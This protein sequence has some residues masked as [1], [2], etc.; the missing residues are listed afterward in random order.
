MEIGETWAYHS[1]TT[2]AVVPVAIVKVPTDQPARVLVRFTQAEAEGS[3]EWVP[4]GR[5]KVPWDGVDEWLE[6]DRRWTAI[7]ET[8]RRD[9][10]DPEWNAAEIVLEQCLDQSLAE[11]GVNQDAGLLLIKD[12]A[13]LAALLDIEATELSSDPLSFVVDGTL[14]VPSAVTVRVTRRAAELNAAALLDSVEREEARG[15]HEA[16]H[17]R[18]YPAHGRGRGWYVKPE[19]CAENAEQDRLIHQLIRRWCGVEGQAR[20]DE[21]KA[22]R[23]EARRLAQLAGR[24]IAALR[25]TDDAAA[26]ELERELGVPIETLRHQQ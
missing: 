6:L 4:A 7:R 1:R 16:L 5:L 21:L 9:W 17:G 26:T 15:R 19:I 14:V 2:G 25:Q 8:S 13:G 10:L 11:G 18:Y 3:E 20:Y 12:V 24:A 23:A 22:L